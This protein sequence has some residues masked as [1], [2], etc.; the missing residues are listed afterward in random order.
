MTAISAI[1]ATCN[2]QVFLEEAIDSL[3]RQSRPVD[4]IVIWDDGSTDGT[5]TYGRALAKR[6]P[7]QILYRRSQNRGKSCALNAALQET[8][9][10]YIWVCD[11]DDIALPFAAERLAGRLDGTDA[12][13]AAGRHERFRDDP[14]T[15]RRETMGTGY[16]PDLSE[17]TVL[18]HLL[19][20]VFFFQNASLVR[21]E[22]LD[23]V[24]PYREDL[25]R[26]IDYEMFVRLASRYPIEMIDE[27]LFHQRKHDGAR[28]PASLRHAADTSEQVWMEFD[29]KIFAD[30]REVLPLS[31]Y[32]ALFDSA[33]PPLR[34]RAALLQRGCVYAR[35]SDWEAAL[36]DFSSAAGLRPKTPLTEIERQIAIR[37]LAGKHGCSTAFRNPIAER[38]ARLRRRGVAGRSLAAA[39][40]RGALWRGRVA[41]AQKD[42]TEL[43]RI[44]G[45]VARMSGFAPTHADPAGAAHDLREKR[46][47]APHDY[48]W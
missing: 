46:T 40:G 47:L 12:G 9:G 6:A 22:A 16:W 5:E 41:M 15:G 13:L 43:A 19:E 1:V 2:R 17:G 33:D 42:L 21:R 45:F 38:L 3:Q 35:R 18:R 37:A 25:P 30:F 8:T 36:C 32:E 27:V 29:R 48:A 31:L 20:D 39:L 34:S 4:Q 14:R 26:S 11:D 44:A 23:R 10:A 7:G 24:G 28:G